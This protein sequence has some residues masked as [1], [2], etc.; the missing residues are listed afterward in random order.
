MS[1][2]ESILAALFT[3][4]GLIVGPKVMRNEALPT[5]IP[6]GGI[7]V[8]RDGDPG[9]PE[10]TLSP[11]TYHYEHRAEIEI[12]VQVK[13]DQDA[14]FDALAVAIGIRIAA[15]R[16]LG[17]LC[18]WTE[19]MAPV[20]VELVLEGGEPMKAAVIPVMLVYSTTNPI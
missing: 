15:N 5:R 14:V 8:L 1:T 18:D 6:A 12:L 4:L 19:G 20:P 10:V 2:R 13:T 11:L 17:G 9:A 16:T 7:L 3:S